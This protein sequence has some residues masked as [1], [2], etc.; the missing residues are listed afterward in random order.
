[1][2]LRMARLIK[3][4]SNWLLKVRVPADIVDQVRR[5]VVLP[6]GGRRMPVAISAG[7][8]EVGLHLRPR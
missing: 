8:V 1:M 7:Y 5:H 2:A 4:V 3:R 6:I